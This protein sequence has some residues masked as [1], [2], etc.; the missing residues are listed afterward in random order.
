MLF[1]DKRSIQS[2]VAKAFA[3]M[4]VQGTPIGAEKVQR[5]VAACGINPQDN[6]FSRAIIDMREEMLFS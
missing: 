5:M 4:G 1:V 3:E 6:T 2:Q